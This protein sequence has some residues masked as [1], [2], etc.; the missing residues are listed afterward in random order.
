MHGV[1]CMVVIVQWQWNVCTGYIRAFRAAPAVACELELEEI[2]SH[3][4]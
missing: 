4:H 2:C 1:L 3:F